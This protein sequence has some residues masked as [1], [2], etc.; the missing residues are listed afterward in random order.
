MCTGAGGGGFILNIYCEAN[1][2]LYLFLR[3]FL[4][5]S[6][7]SG[8]SVTREELPC[9]RSLVTGFSLQSFGFDLNSVHVSLVVDKVALRVVFLPVLQ[10]PLSVSFHQCSVLIHSSTTDAV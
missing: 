7:I 5:Y 1:H 8:Q 4:F 2:A 9:F 10:F 6:S 3:I